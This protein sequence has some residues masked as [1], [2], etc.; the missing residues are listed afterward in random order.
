MKVGGEVHIF[1]VYY[2]GLLY[3]T[4][5]VTEVEG[6]ACGAEEIRKV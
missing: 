5:G 1:G 6:L 3:S 4:E 2:L